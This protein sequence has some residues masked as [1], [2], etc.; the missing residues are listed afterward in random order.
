MKA[1]GRILLGKPITTAMLH[2]QIEETGKFE[3]AIPVGD[4]AASNDETA[5][6]A[7]FVHQKLRSP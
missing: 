4:R 2:R 3:G 5:P 7:N 6:E 1:E